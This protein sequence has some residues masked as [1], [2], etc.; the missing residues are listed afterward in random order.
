MDNNM[1]KG[2]IFLLLA[3]FLVSCT[4]QISNK[5]EIQDSNASIGFIG[6]SNTRQTVYG[7]GLA[8]GQNIW[9]VEM[10]NI[11]DYDSGAVFQWINND[12]HFWEVFDKYHNNNPQTNKIW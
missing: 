3:I 2:A 9:E 12:E 10:D 6:C 4:Q 8:G 5:E 1:K 7:Y 11:H